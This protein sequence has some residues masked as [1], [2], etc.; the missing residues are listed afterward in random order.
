MYSSLLARICLL[1]MFV[2]LKKVEEE[3]ERLLSEKKAIEE[4]KQHLEEDVQ[5]QT[6]EFKR[7]KQV[8]VSLR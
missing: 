6:R 2:M 3:E 7:S 4:Q 5:V 1:R 8:G